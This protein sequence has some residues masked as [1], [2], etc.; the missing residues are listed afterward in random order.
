M[1]LVAGDFTKLIQEHCAG[2][3]RCASLARSLTRVAQASMLAAHAGTLAASEHGRK[4]LYW[5]LISV[6]PP[7]RLRAARQL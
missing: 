5:G 3:V 2:T 6:D 1:C 4:Q 7:T